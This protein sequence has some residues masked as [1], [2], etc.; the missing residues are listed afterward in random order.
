M[1]GDDDVVLY[2]GKANNLQQRLRQYFAPSGDGRE[3]IPYLVQR[4]AHIDTI[5]V[6][7]EKEALLLENTLIKKHQPRFNVLLKDDKG[8]LALRVTVK[9]TWPQLQFVRYKG[10]INAQDLYFGPYSNVAAARATFDLLSR[11]FPLRQCSDSE[12]RKRTRPCI[13]YDIKR[14]LAPCVGKCTPAEY[15][16]HVSKTIRFLRGENKEILKE[17][18]QSMNEASERLE[19][20]KAGG[21]L[22]T[23]RYIETTTEKQSV[24]APQGADRDVIGIYRQ[25]GDVVLQLLIYKGGQLIASKHFDFVDIVQE[26]NELLSSFILQRY[27]GKSELP[28]EI[29]IG[30]I[31]ADQ[32]LLAEIISK[33]HKKSTSI[34]C[35]QKG[36]KKVLVDM[37]YTNA[38]ATFNKEKDLHLLREKMLL[39]MQD[40]LALKNFPQRIECFDNSHFSGSSPVSALVVFV[41]GEKEP[42]SYRKYKGQTN[43][44]ADDYAAMREVLSR[45]F[46]GAKEGLPDLLMVDGGKGQLGVAREVLREFDIVTVDIIAIAKDTGRH[47]KGLT[48]ERIFLSEKDEPIILKSASP[49]LFLLQQIRDEAHRFA[50]S[51]QRHVRTKA[52]SKSKLDSVPGI[53][54]KKKKALLQHFGSVKK[55]Q[56]AHAEDLRQLK[57]LNK[58]DVEA[59]LKN[60]I[61]PDN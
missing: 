51:Y 42:K 55:I 38:K 58:S 28:E 52:V 57:F 10:K 24:H 46:R 12:F 49:I 56:E 5:V 41:G 4:V 19:F 32:E 35:P 6:R 43:C 27:E 39:E 7:S 11:L 21:I 22:R 33:E 40:K 30:E 37:A 36:E 20:E 13:L 1:K 16:L 34:T 29:L 48:Q 18:Y 26:T 14:C 59:L 17:L 53:G 2:V 44:G 60:I 54:P 61:L 8:Y 9:K 50:I 45:R 47:D 15:A 3:M 23:I 31:S 25:G